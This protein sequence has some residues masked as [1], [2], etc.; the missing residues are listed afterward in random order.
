MGSPCPYPRPS[1]PIQDVSPRH[2]PSLGERPSQAHAQRTLGR[3]QPEWPLVPPFL[4]L[5][6]CREAWGPVAGGH[7]W[8]DQSLRHAGRVLP[9]APAAPPGHTGLGGGDRMWTCGSA[10][11]LPSQ[12]YLGSMEA[13]AAARLWPT[14][15]GA[16]LATRG[17]TRRSQGWTPGLAPLPPSALLPA[18]PRATRPQRQGAGAWPRKWEPGE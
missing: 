11:P 14:E 16:A 5:L 8:E 3:R 10:M 7:T 6:L 1:P 2:P 13:G 9:A 17:P 12:K 18:P 15:D 4:Q